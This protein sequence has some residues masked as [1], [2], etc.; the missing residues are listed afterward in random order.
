[1][2]R[3]PIKTDWFSYFYWKNFHRRTQ[4]TLVIAHVTYHKAY[5]NY[6][7]L[8][9]IREWFTLIQ[10]RVVYSQN[11]I[12]I[13]NSSRVF[14]KYYSSI[15]TYKLT[16]S[17][18]ENI[19]IYELSIFICNMIFNLMCTNHIIVGSMHFKV[20]CTRLFFVQP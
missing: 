8:D 7:K 1:M 11:E 14:S 9:Q 16:I 6:T 13:C 10:K 19:A 17:R 18:K 3:L 2:F 15:K 20:S 4:C 12:T 5:I